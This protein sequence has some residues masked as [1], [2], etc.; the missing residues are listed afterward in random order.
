MN[1]QINQP[2]SVEEGARL[3]HYTL[4]KQD[5]ADAVRAAKQL[6]E[7]RR[8]ATEVEHCQALLVKLAEDRFNLA[9]VGQFKRGKSSLMN[10][11]IGRDLLPTGV[12]PLTSA[13]TALCYGPAE[14]VLLKHKGW[15]FVHEVPLSE[16]GD[17]VTEQGNPGN[18][19][20]L[21]EARIEIPVPFLRRG[22][23]FIDTPGI[24][25]A[26]RENTATTYAFLPEADA[27]IFVTSVE[28][29]LSEA[30][31]GFLEEI[32]EHARKLF[33]AVNKVDL[34]GT[35]ERESVLR[36][37]HEGIART[38][39]LDG[40]HLLPLSAHQGLAA[41]LG[42]D[43]PGI[44]AS[45][46]ENFENALVGFLGAEKEQSF[47]AAIL[48]RAVRLLP[49]GSGDFTVVRARIESLHAQLLGSGAGAGAWQPWKAESVDPRLLERAF[50][51]GRENEGPREERAGVRID[52]C[53]IC[54]AQS[55]TLFNMLARW[56][57]LLATDDASRRAFA[58]ARGFCHMHTWQ[59]QELASSLGISEGY[60]PL[61]AAAAAE[62]REASELP[63]EVGVARIAALV[64]AGETCPACRVLRE[65]EGDRVRRCLDELASADDGRSRAQSP[66]LCLPHLKAVLARSPSPETTALLLREEGRRLEE[67]S[68]DLRSYALKRD[69]LRR[70]LL[71]ADEESAWRR[72]LILLS[73]ERTGRGP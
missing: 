12:L 46:L 42:G 68:E 59:F 11:V 20:G 34:L 65:S 54:A 6:F 40:V 63:P 32:R 13:I 8:A 71:N 21:L 38:L 2:E 53:H 48:E 17:Y 52:G 7:A 64:P 57:F 24:G 47:L 23:H 51:A 67:L 26:R 73:G 45:G 29:P 70:A 72:A 4:A 5:V 9:V 15:A 35:A 62:L 19:K 1:P 28:A 66:G 56:Q 30:E 16:L 55:Q 41:K 33:V 39:T 43:G 3:K 10:A 49:A 22:L 50:A 18:E 25:S 58:D 37:I 61:I 27:V 60:A 44:R 14:R 69:A 36:Y 31:H